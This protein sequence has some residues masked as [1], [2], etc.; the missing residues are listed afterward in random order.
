MAKESFAYRLLVPEKSFIQSPNFWLVHS[1]AMPNAI[2]PPSLGQRPSR[3][4]NTMKL[5]RLI[6]NQLTAD[7]I[8]SGR[9]YNL[10]FQIY[11]SNRN[12]AVHLHDL[13]RFVRVLPPT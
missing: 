7:P 12:A 1:E 9:K 4:D 11:F 10:V 8:Y 5:L 2:C 6:A 13:C 3:Y